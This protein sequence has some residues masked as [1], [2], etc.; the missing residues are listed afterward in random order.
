MRTSAVVLAATLCC[1]A[2]VAAD[3]RPNFTGVW[4]HSDGASWV[5]VTIDHQ[6]PNLRIAYESRFSAGT[7]SGGLS[8][9][10][11]YIADGVE[12]AG[13]GNNRR[14]SWT[15]VN[16]QGPAL[17]ILRVTRDG[18]RVVVTREAWT[19]SGDGR[20]LTKDKRTIDMDDVT[21]SS[22]VFRKQ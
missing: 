13:D 8:G 9:A 20:T 19:L 7:L 21:E 22:Q 10:G 16:W 14:A 3:N 5:V 6:E 4:K 12:R 11:N 2:A 18:Y 17:V 15:T 1:I